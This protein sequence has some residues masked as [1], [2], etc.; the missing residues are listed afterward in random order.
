MVQD[1]KVIQYNVDTFLPFVLTTSI[2]IFFDTDVTIIAKKFSF[3]LTSLIG[4]CNQNGMWNTFSS[5]LIIK[6][7][8]FSEIVKKNEVTGGILGTNTH[9]P[10]S[11]TEEPLNILMTLK[12]RV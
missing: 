4:M 6:M 1:L 10:Y 9:W 3:M 5:L 7:I 12:V 11:A 2:I 8:F